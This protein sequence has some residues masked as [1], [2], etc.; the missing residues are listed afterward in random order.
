MVESRYL[1]D[2]GTELKYGMLLTFLEP[3][4]IDN[5]LSIGVPDKCLDGAHILVK[6]GAGNT[7]TIVH[8]N[9]YIHKHFEPN[10]D[11]FGPYENNVWFVID[12]EKIETCIGKV[13]T[14]EIDDRG[15]Y[16]RFDIKKPWLALQ[17]IQTLNAGYR[18]VFPQVVLEQVSLSD[19]P[20]PHA[21]KIMATTPIEKIYCLNV[22]PK[23]QSLRAISKQ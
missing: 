18:D 22:T 5:L 17:D 13:A 9:D 10:I 23:D 4:D 6:D 19:V 12:R 2:K 21:R 14:Y 11:F 8:N 1:P 20:L 3:N 15:S 7:S 16:I